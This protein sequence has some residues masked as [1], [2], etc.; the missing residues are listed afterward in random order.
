[1]L[2]VGIY[3]KTAKPKIDLQIQIPLPPVEEVTSDCETRTV[4]GIGEEVELKVLPVELSNIDETTWSIVASDGGAEGILTVKTQNNGNPNS[5][6]QTI[7][8]ANN[9]Q[10]EPPAPPSEV[11]GASVMLKIKVNRVQQNACLTVMAELKTRETL[12]INF[13]VLMPQSWRIVYNRGPNGTSPWGGA[14]DESEN[15]LDGGSNNDAEI[16]TSSE[17]PSIIFSIP[18]RNIDMLCNP[19]TVNFEYVFSQEVDD[20]SPI[21]MVPEGGTGEYFFGHY[22]RSTGDHPD[23]APRP[24]DEEDKRIRQ[25]NYEGGFGDMFDG[26]GG[27]IAGRRWKDP[28]RISHNYPTDAELKESIDNNGEHSFSWDCG[29]KLYETNKLP[30]PESFA[31]MTSCKQK[32]S[33]GY[34]QGSAGGYYTK[35]SKWNSDSVRILELYPRRIRDVSTPQGAMSQ[36]SLQVDLSKKN[37][38]QP[39]KTK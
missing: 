18:W 37:L 36:A 29:W 23:G 1:M 13:D 26:V 6:P 35:A 28:D 27:G 38:T 2:E 31:R 24:G 20:G 30:I 22:T 33:A 16:G 15:T 3:H 34:S 10:E 8:I 4:V 12:F 19:S 17:E 25:I 7:E 11:K 9:N 32:M 21:D 14:G 39:K 5:N